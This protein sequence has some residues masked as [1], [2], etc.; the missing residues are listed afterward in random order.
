MYRPSFDLDALRTFVCVV[1]FSG[2]TAAAASLAKTQSTVSHQIRRLEEQLG[3]SLLERTTRS[4]ALTPAGE[5]FL[6]DAKSIL[7]LAESSVARLKAIQIRGEVRL[8]VPEEIACSVLPDVVSIFRRSYPDIRVA[9]TVGVSGN[10]RRLAE[11]GELDLAV[12]KQAPA[13]KMAL[14]VEPLAWVGRP[15]IS[16]SSPLPVAFF[17]EPCEF[18][19]RAIEALQGERRPYD[20]IMTTT[21]YQSLRAVCSR[22]IAITVLA[23]SDCPQGL[24]LG[25]AGVQQAE[26]PALP[27]M[28]YVIQQ[29]VKSSAASSALSA[30]LSQALAVR[31]RPTELW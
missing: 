24:L 14:G 19:A 12:I 21:S 15:H 7:E 29:G 17:P 2:F 4:V 26:L 9:I 6:E 10:L 22:G 13:S 18:R 23:A 20:V 1:N 27:P 16:R 28:G 30:A 11:I 25:K 3:C 8:G 31:Q 5:R